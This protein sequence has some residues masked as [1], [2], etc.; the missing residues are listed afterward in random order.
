M[1]DL[2]LA[3]GERIYRHEVPVDDRFHTVA[4]Q[5]T[6][7][8]VACRRT[9]TVEFWAPWS[10]DLEPR[11]RTFIVVG[12]GQSMPDDLSYRGTA[13]APNGLVWHLMERL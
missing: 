11:Q 3:K 8:H 1:S 4:I 12:T 5:G 7:L 6:P 2:P 10:D 13:L 9:L